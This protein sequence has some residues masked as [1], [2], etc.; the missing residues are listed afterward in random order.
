MRL[1]IFWVLG[2]RLGFRVWGL[3]C[4]YSYALMRFLD[5]NLLHAGHRQPVRFVED[6][7]LAYILT[8]YRQVRVYRQV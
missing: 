1:G 3:G 2:V 5:T 6:E 8:R 4:M 7:E